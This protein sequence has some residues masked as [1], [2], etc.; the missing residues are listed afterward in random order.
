MTFVSSWKTVGLFVSRFVFFENI[1]ACFKL[2]FVFNHHAP[3][4]SPNPFFF[5]SISSLSLFTITI[6]SSSFT[7]T[8]F[9][10]PHL[11]KNPTAT[12]YRPHTGALA[13]TVHKL[14][15]EDEAQVEKVLDLLRDYVTRRRITMLYPFFKDF[16]RVRPSLLAIFV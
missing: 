3:R 15:P 4:F 16:D 6:T 12:V 9:N 5:C 13:H 10:V 2:S 7:H 1:Q 8:A 11:E 14:D